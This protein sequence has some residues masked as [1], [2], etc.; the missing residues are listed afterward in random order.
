M[1]RIRTALRTAGGRFF[2]EGKGVEGRHGAVE[3]AADIGG[4]ELEPDGAEE[5]AEG[6]SRPCGPLLQDLLD[7]VQPVLDPLDGRR[8]ENLLAAPA[9]AVD[10]LGE[11]VDAALGLD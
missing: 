3:G 11:R 1:Q 2:Y 7:V 6:L 10:F 5:V 4:D 9:Q 8:P